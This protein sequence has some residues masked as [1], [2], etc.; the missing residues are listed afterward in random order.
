M[1]KENRRMERQIESWNIGEYV[2]LNPNKRPYIDMATVETVM[3]DQDYQIVS[4]KMEIYDLEKELEG[5]EEEATKL[6][7][8]NKNVKNICRLLNNE[9]A[10][11][12]I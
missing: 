10:S 5:K 2:N 9:I 12:K 6:T 7:E 4:M 11:K 8:K 1:E 3:A